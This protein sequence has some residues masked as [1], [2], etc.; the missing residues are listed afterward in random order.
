M[1]SIGEFAKKIGV[2][3]QTLRDWDKSGKLKP[4]YRSKGNHRYYSEDQLNEILQKRVPNDR[5]N[6]G[7]VRVSANHPKDDLRQQYE[8]M[9]LFLTKKL[10]K[11]LKNEREKIELKTFEIRVTNTKD[12]NYLK[13]YICKYRHW[14]NILT[15]L[16]INL[17]KAD[18]EDYKHFLDYAIV[19]A[20]I[21]NTK[22]D[23]KKIETIAYVKEKYKDN[24]LYKDLV[25]VGQ[26][27]KTHNLVEIVKR[28]KKD[29]SNYFKALKDYKKNPD[30]Y[31]GLP[32]L[33][34]AKKLSQL[35]NYSIPLDSFN[36]ISFKK[37][38]VVGINL[39][40]KMRYF[41][42]GETDEINIFKN[43]EIKSVKVKFQNNQ[44]YLQ[45]TYN[46]LNDIP[47]TN[48][49]LTK[50]AGLDIGLNNIISLFVD[51]KTTPSLII[52]GAKYKYYNYR[53]N[54]QV[55]KL[56]ETISSEAIEFKKSKTGTEY[57]VKWSE[58]GNYLK[59]FKTY[60]TQKRNEY[61]KNSFHKLSKKVV[62]YLQ[63]H[64]V[65]HLVISSSLA[66]LKNNGNCNLRKST[67]QNFIQI[68]FIQLLNYIE[69]KATDLG[70]EIVK[71]DE[72][73]T[74]KISCLS[75]DVCDVQEYSN[76]LHQKREESACTTRPKY[77][78]KRTHRGLF[79]D[80]AINKIFNA[81]LNGAVNHIKLTIK[82]SFHWLKDNLWKLCNPIKLKSAGELHS[83]LCNIRSN[84][85][86][87]VGGQTEIYERRKTTAR[88]YRY[89][90]S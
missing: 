56:N 12:Q 79:K 62:K 19:R 58:K 35:T 18:N 28:L 5:I 42:I 26:E 8:L 21:A 77:N 80:T 31:T 50:F 16:T 51:D 73:Y 13:N 63:L 37:K 3:I 78:G 83:L 32:Q 65:T 34:K 53:Y 2:T 41:Y 47:I 76:A 25:S 43:N 17:F 40:S 6:V 10:S 44:I 22:G 48:T 1:Y 82:K 4:A 52:D 61:F 67:K 30:K 84:K 60:L 75:G 45:F 55:A 70:I 38:N 85:S 33:L 90:I 39:N 89:A 11:S 9:E 14:Q 72:A 87:S 49:Q 54:K 36:S 27:L 81:D 86:L 20:C 68:P 88:A 29:F 23:K 64:N 59:E 57:P 46:K 15:I 24:K 7:Y 74:S 71:V 69:E 66:E